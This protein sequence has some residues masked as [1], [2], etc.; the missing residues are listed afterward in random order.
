VASNQEQELPSIDQTE[1]P[2]RNNPSSSQVGSNQGQ[3]VSSI[4]NTQQV[5][6]D[7]GKKRA[8]S[9]TEATYD[10]EKLN[11]HK[12]NFF[13]SDNTTLDN[14]IIEGVQ[15]NSSANLQSK[16]N[17]AITKNDFFN[18]SLN[19][20]S[21]YAKISNLIESG[22]IKPTDRLGML[23]FEPE[24]LR[25]KFYEII[26]TLGFTK[27][28]KCSE[29]R[30]GTIKNKLESYIDVTYINANSIKEEDFAD[31][32]L[33]YNSIYVKISNLIESGQI[34]PND[35]LAKLIFEPE[36]LRNIFYERIKT[37]GL[38]KI[39]YANQSYIGVLQKTLKSK[40]G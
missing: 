35:R 32:S 13:V 4:D 33:N 30:I 21:I 37:L 31:Q 34:K 22:Q 5:F 10:T 9:D 23:I 15:E 20:N 2:L 36:D 39:K 14:V 19:Y 8:L 38:T 17:K 25:K 1:I 3:Q 11:T 6:K 12:K 24:D 7:K 26:K 28:T 29:I 40:L 18:Q 27:N 16:E